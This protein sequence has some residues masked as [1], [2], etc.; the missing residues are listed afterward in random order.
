MEHVFSEL[1]KVLGVTCKNYKSVTTFAF[2]EQFKSKIHFF[3]KK[4]FCVLKTTG[5]ILNWESIPWKKPYL[6]DVIIQD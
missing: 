1:L 5:K 4:K 3:I 6:L 2:Q